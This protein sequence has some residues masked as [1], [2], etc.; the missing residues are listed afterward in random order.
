MINKLIKYIFIF[1]FTFKAGNAIEKNLYKCNFQSYAYTWGKILVL[2]SK[3]Y[4]QT[5]KLNFSFQEH[6]EQEHAID[7]KEY[8]KTFDIEEEVELEPENE[9]ENLGMIQS[10]TS[11]YISSAALITKQG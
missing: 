1:K 7:V 10:R 5:Y 11:V 4:I 8:A 3:K 2:V 9:D 6:L